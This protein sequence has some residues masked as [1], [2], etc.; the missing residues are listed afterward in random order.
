ME[1]TEHEAASQQR[2]ESLKEAIKKGRKMSDTPHIKNIFEPSPMGY[3]AGWGGTGAGGLAG[4][5]AGVLGG[6][7]GGALL[8]NG[9]LF[10]NRHGGDCVTPMQ[11]QTSTASIIDA[12]Q[13]T[14]IMS[15]LQ[16]IATSVPVAEGQVQLAL[17]QSTGQLA[18]QINTN[19]VS[20]TQGFANVNDNVNKN[21]ANIIAVGESIKDTV[22]MTSAA[23]QAAV[24]AS[25]TQGLQNTFALSQA[26]NNDGDK[27]RALIESINNANLQR[28]LTVADLDRRDE[29]NRA[30]SREVEVNVTQTVN[31]NQAQLQAQAQQQQQF[32]V[33]NGILQ[34]LAG[35]Q[36]AIAT[37]SN[38]IIGNSG[39]VGTG[40]QTANPINVA[41]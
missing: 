18:N 30:R 6:L 10:G 34:Q 36:T 7:F 11:L 20:A 39:A 15:M 26:I 27:T 9:G 40:P 25:V 23:T 29:A 2:Y 35:M 5:G 21:T 13:N 16:G 3:G 17:A 12:N 31:Q 22:N 38:M 8:N 24:A 37:N 14:Q 32:L 33:L 28:Q 1:L 19:L 41:R 4:A